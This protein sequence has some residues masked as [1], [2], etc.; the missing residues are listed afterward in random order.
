MIWDETRLPVGNSKTVGKGTRICQYNDSHLKT[1]LQPS[2]ET[3]C[4]SNT[5]QTMGNV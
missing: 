2:T 3:S 1:G 5:P 4:I